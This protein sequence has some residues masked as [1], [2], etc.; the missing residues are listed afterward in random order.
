M[1]PA[2]KTAGTTVMVL[3]LL[4]GAAAL[5]YARWTSPIAVG[6]RALA[7]GQ[8][9]AA[10]AAYTEAEARFDRAPALKQFIPADYAH[11]TGNELWVLY[12]EGRTDQVI[13]KADRSPESA[14]PH[15][16]AGLAFFAKAR[17]ESKSDAQLGWLTRA[18][19]ELRKA[20]EAQPGDW[21]TKY[22]FELV[23]RLAAA[24]R[25]NPKTP[26]AQLMQIIRPEQKP[27]TRPERRV[28]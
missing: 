8:L 5:A 28:G 17:A 13:A 19:E 20:V 16:W 12:R 9:D 15:L 23:S 1:T 4:A 3:L 7:A 25:K 2:A 22:D 14:S 21:D 24:L 27:G 10:L 18:E 11:V 26:P 6:D